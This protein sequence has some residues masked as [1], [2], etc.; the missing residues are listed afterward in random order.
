[1]KILKR[2]AGLALALFMS[3]SFGGLV[4]CDGA[5]NSGVNERLPATDTENPSGGTKPDDIENPVDDKELKAKKEKFLLSLSEQATDALRFDAEIGYSTTQSV[6]TGSSGASKKVVRSS[7]D[8]MTACGGVE[9]ASSDIDLAVLDEKTT[10]VGSLTASV[11][12]ASYY[13]NRNG[14]LFK[15]VEKGNVL[16][17]DYSK[18][19]FEYGGEIAKEHKSVID[20]IFAIKNK[21]RVLYVLAKLADA[22]GELKLGAGFA[23]VDVNAVLYKIA[24][25][26]NAAV[27]S[28]GATTSVGAFLENAAIKK[29]LSAVA[30]IVPVERVYAFVAFLPIAATSIDKLPDEVF[31]SYGITR[32]QVEFI[33]SKLSGVDLTKL[34]KILPD[35]GSTTYDYI[36]KLLKSN[37]LRDAV[38]AV[39][40]KNGESVSNLPK[41]SDVAIASV[42]PIVG[43]AIGIRDLSELK[44]QVGALVTNSFTKEEFH[45]TVGDA[46]KDGKSGATS[47]S[48]STSYKLRDAEVKFVLD[49]DGKSGE[50][51]VSFLLL[52][53]GNVAAAGE[54][55]LNETSLSLDAKVAF[56]ASVALA[57]VDNCAAEYKAS[58]IK[59]VKESVEFNRR[60]IDGNDGKAT[61]EFVAATDDDGNL[62]GINVVNSVGEIISKDDAFK[63]TF[64]GTDG[65]GE[66]FTLKYTYLQ[67]DGGD[68]KIVVSSDNKQIRIVMLFSKNTT[69]KSTVAQLAN[70]GATESK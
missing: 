44:K 41:L 5:P 7:V 15:S 21:A 26:V 20:E 49:D 47:V 52:K 31:E 14:H 68:V 8:D 66:E 4:A 61:V 18:L 22:A 70:R 58:S 40:S 27:D 43:N 35:A 33:L 59:G 16:T 46:G 34:A 11:N 2:A 55:L 64:V 54:T 13:F 63:L 36:L 23:T 1:M 53:S 10:S 30:E 19:S 25:D 45:F 32:A 12:T 17:D 65:A 38:N 67:Y 57:N 29:Y 37:E 56:C 50:Q 28:I 42:L 39:L 3:V 9:F 24:T 60:D 51:N 48:S 62:T 69:F 6:I